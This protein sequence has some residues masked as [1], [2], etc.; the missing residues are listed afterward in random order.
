MK[1]DL[2][3]YNAL[4]PKTAKV[5]RDLS[6]QPFLANFTFVGGS[7]L[8]LYLKHRQSEDLDF[9][10]WEK[11]I[12][13]SIIQNTIQAQFIDFQLI[14]DS[15]LQQD[16]LIEGVKVT[17]FANNWAALQQRN[18]LENQLYVIDLEVLSAMKVNTLFLRAKYR[19]YY[20]LYAIVKS[21]V[22]VQKL[23]ETAVKFLP[24]MNTK[25]FQM[26]LVYTEDILED[27]INYLYPIYKITKNKISAF[28]QKEL[29]K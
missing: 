2:T 12:D 18:L 11:E 14:N 7:A 4:L 13:K 28:F 16:W 9:F 27:N 22:S 10:T 24:N 26:A 5:L 3:A 1:L 15:K 17:F 6:V 19:D 23:Y 20:D 25:L 8:A 29:A 21:G